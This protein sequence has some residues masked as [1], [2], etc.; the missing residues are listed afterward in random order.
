MRR[1]LV[2]SA[3]LLVMGCGRRE[4]VKWDQLANSDAVKI[5]RVPENPYRII[6]GP[7]P[8]LAKKPGS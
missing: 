4:P 5:L 1:L 8:D 2:L 3:L 6:Y 7:A